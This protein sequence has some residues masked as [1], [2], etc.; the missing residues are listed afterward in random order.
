MKL[1]KLENFV[2]VVGGQIMTRVTVGEKDEKVGSWKVVIPKA[3]SSDGLVNVDVM[4]VEDLKAEPD[5]KKIT[6]VG[7]IVIKLSS[8]FD[9][10]VVTEEAVGCIVP[11]FCAIIR[12]KGELDNYFLSAFLNSVY[13][14]EQLKANVSGGTVMSILSNGKIKDVM[15]PVPSKQKQIEI[16]ERYKKSLEKIRIVNEIVELETQ[17]ND[18]VFQELLNDGE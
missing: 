1:V 3:I 14:K 12:N 6:A 5:E 2:D 15:I 17:R 13:C 4:P 16:G 18:I 9:S 11:S 7:D 8:P 10:A